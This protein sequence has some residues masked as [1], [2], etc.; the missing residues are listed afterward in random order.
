MSAFRRFI[1]PF[2][3][4]AATVA[5]P[6]AA[7]T[8]D[9][10]LRD[11]FAIG[12]A[13]G[14][15]CRVQATVRDSVIAGMFDRAWVILCR[16]AAQ[17][18]GYVRMLRASPQQA[19]S[20]VEQNRAGMID[21]DAGGGCIVRGTRAPWQ[22][23]T[24]ESGASS[25]IVE[26]YEGYGDALKLALQ[27]LVE[28][29]VAAGVIRVA[30]T[31]IDGDDG[32]ART[33]AGNIDVDKALA[34]GY[35]R[36]QSGN[37][38]AAAEF[39][40]TLS[41][42]S[43]DLDPASGLDPS[44]FTLNAALQKSNLGDF[45]EADR[46]FAEALAS[47]TTNL[48]QLRLRRNFQAIHALNQRDY[49]GAIILLDTPLPP[50]SSAVLRDDDK[51]V[52]TP[53]I[54]MGINEGSDA[55]RIKQLS[56][57]ERLTPFE[58]AAIIDAQAVHLRGTAQRLTGKPA[59]AKS[60]Q[61][62]AL[63][64]ASAV[65]EG[66]VTSIVRLRSQMLGELALA[67]ED[68]GD[69]EAARS[70]FL[71]SISVLA[72]EY[73]ETN[74]LASAR[75]RYAAFLTRNQ[76]YD[77]ALALYREVVA[78]LAKTRRTATGMA[79]QFAP[80][81]RLLAER[82]ASDPQAVA[83]FFQ[84]SQLLVRPGVADT[85]A[86]LARELSSG[87]DEG[88]RLFRQAT[89]LARDIERA[90]IEDARLAQLPESAEIT[91][92]R[93]DVA[94][95]ISTLAASQAETLVTLSGYPKYRVVE[96]NSLTLDELRAALHPG[97]A[98]AKML[99]VGDDVYVMLADPAGGQMWRADVDRAGLDRN[100]DLVR[101]TIS[102][103][104]NGRRVTYPFDA[105][106][107][108]NLYTR[109]FGPVADRLPTI[110]NLF[111]EPDGAMLRLP[112]NLL[113]TSNKGIAAYEQRL[114]D[115]AA[116]AFDMRD[117]AWLGRTTRASTAV[118][119]MSFRNARQTEASKATRQYFG[120]GQNQPATGNPIA[121]ATRGMAGQAGLNCDWALSA[122]N[123]PIPADELLNA[124][125]LLGQ[126]QSSILTGRDFSDNAVKARTDL[127]EYR[128]LHF[129][130]HGL[131]T[132]PRPQCPAR[133]ALLTSFGGEG[134]DGLL[135]FQEI[136]DLRID[137]DLVILSACDTAGAATVTATRE[138]GVS[139]GGGSALDGLVRA[140]IGAG[141]RTVI[142]SHWPVPED[143]DATKRLIGG[144]FSAAAGTSIAD[145]LW[146]TQTQLMAQA[147]TSHP[148]YWAG[149]AIIGDGTQPL[150]RPTTTPV[151]ASAA[152][153]AGG[154]AF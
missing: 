113:I 47:P 122:W 43:G 148:Y 46:L 116:D 33:L 106:A 145:A 87:S 28:R 127:N 78:D 149:F 120:F 67:E 150:V 80:Y 23:I 75:T 71:E 54:A 39:F 73:P 27:S 115:P 42:R 14:S 89:T 105:A 85:Q 2:A 52:L 135:S 147:N 53:E 26:G 48:V 16:D 65:R 131:V 123:Q 36:N 62:Q 77:A 94:R 93:G 13:G 140:F 4:L 153:K 128:I 132:A 37:Y 31:T 3:L 101:S 111:F 109:L 19:M 29:R 100:V 130:T 64:Q 104:E 68:L 10:G 97:E 9:P 146:G 74:A 51:I 49:A 72:V 112:V 56:D 136:F 17:P 95:Q 35:R 8:G 76:E 50:L 81:F 60:A 55:G 11:S 18:V 110:A 142:A 5:P 44:E 24:R 34:E 41:R 61:L 118:S 121:A 79:N 117:I 15:L 22:T 32:F 59:D 25:F 58:R 84:A 45:G 1:L 6:A 124:R 108:H 143:F 151:T 119:A 38:A 20:R 154:A 99:V 88:A 91:A 83:D 152:G 107:A 98:Y 57:R 86:I 129:A 69:K 12:D 126:S 21:C 92:L 70:R 125:R 144:L 137:A 134:S 82:A 96:Q 7:Q 114:L 139:S 103:M 133:P 138:A 90:R 40:E 141:G 63:T 66:R 102:T 30:S